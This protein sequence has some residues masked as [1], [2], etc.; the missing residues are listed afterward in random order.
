MA[1][2]IFFA[3]AEMMRNEM[4]FLRERNCSAAIKFAQSFL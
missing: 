2:R 3:P 1:A 4:K